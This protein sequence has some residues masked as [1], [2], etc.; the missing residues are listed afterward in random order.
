MLQKLLKIHPGTASTHQDAAWCYQ[1][2]SQ[3]TLVPEI[4]ML[5]LCLPNIYSW[6]CTFLLQILPRVH[7]VTTNTLHS[8]TFYYKNSQQCPLLLQIIS[9]VPLLLQIL[10]TVHFVTTNTPHSAHWYYKYSPQC[11]L[12][13]QILPTVHLVTTNTPHSSPFYYKYSP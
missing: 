5:R 9:T 13:L 4:L 11:T 3:Y 10:P 2:L 12:L 8:A 1:S 6:R 7:L